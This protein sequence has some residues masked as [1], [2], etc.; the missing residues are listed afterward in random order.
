MSEETIIYLVTMI[1]T[2]VFGQLAKKFNFIESNKIPIQNLVIGIVVML[3]EW[4]IT[5]S[6]NWELITSGLVAGGTYDL[7]HTKEDDEIGNG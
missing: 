2:W 5:D 1:V 7:V 3:I 6:L 4:A